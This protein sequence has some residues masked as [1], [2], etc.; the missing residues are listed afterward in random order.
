MKA[1]RWIV[2]LGTLLI[3]AGA[4]TLS[5]GKLHTIGEI[6][7]YGDKSWIY[8]SIVEGFVTL[9]TLAAFLRHGQ[10]GAWYPW[11][12]GL[13]GFSYSLWA[14]A[15]PESVPVEVVRAIPVMCIPLSVHMFIIIAGLVDQMAQRAAEMKAMEAEAEAD[16]AS[17]GFGFFDEATPEDFAPDD[18]AP[19]SPAPEGQTP[20]IETVPDGQPVKVTRT[21]KVRTS[22]ASR[23][24]YL[25]LARDA[26]TDEK[27]AQW[28]RMADVAAGN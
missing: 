10:R 25:Q 6:A 15:V 20:V 24:T 27:R 1:L 18:N 26:K 2:G 23:E 3:A 11:L 22:L 12:V 5:F 28:L 4:F 16:E 9:C 19:V 8:P 14:N 13:A 17:E 7:G 21:R